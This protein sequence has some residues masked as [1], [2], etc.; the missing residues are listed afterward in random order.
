MRRQAGSETFLRCLKCTIFRSSILSG[1]FFESVI[2]ICAT[3]GDNPHR[4]AADNIEAM[5]DR[6]LP[7]GKFFVNRIHGIIVST[8]DA[9]EIVA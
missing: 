1:Q 8:S 9:F 4:V 7:D 3:F 5:I 6:G 2:E